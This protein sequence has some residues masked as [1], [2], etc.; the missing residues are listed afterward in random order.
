MKKRVSVFCLVFREERHG[1]EPFQRGNAEVHFGAVKLKKSR[2]QR[3]ISVKG[4]K[5]CL[6]QAK[7]RVVPRSI[8]L[9]PYD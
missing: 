4:Y 1:C 5:E 3:V 2:F 6:L 9:R 8:Q 7:I